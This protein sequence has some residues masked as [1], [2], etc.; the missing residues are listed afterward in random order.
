MEVFIATI[1]YPYDFDYETMV[2]VFSTEGKAK[3]ALDKK[4]ADYQQ[5]SS[6]SDGEMKYIPRNISRH[7]LDISE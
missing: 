4:L 2:G 5:L 7:T 6:R 1:Q 3:E